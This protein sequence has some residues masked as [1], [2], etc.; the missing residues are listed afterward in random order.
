M[1]LP[2]EKLLRQLWFYCFYM[3]TV[4]REFTALGATLAKLTD[5]WCFK[6]G[7]DEQDGDNVKTPEAIRNIENVRQTLE[8]INHYLER[9][10][11]N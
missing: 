8:D 3:H 4:Q 9:K 6:E 10:K 1:G 11:W 7:L 2:R 5:A